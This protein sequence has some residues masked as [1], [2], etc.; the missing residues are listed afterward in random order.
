MMQ[1][2][3]PIERVGVQKAVYPIE[4]KAFPNWD[5]KED[6]NKPDGAVCPC[7][8]WRISIGH[9]PPNQRFISSPDCDTRSQ[10]PK[11]IVGQLAL[12]REHTPRSWIR[13]WV[14]FVI[15]T[16]QVGTVENAVQSVG[17]DKGQNEIPNPNSD[18]P[19]PKRLGGIQR[20]A[21]PPKR[22]KGQSNNHK[23][24]AEGKPRADIPA[25]Q[26]QR[27]PWPSPKR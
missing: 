14:V 7:Q 2:M 25:Q 18:N 1:R 10:C 20:R 9:G 11:H 26:I 17:H 16:L 12:K 15:W 6:G 8:A 13:A 5:Q 22:T 23:V 19:W 3:K 27:F 21:G 4:I 24:N